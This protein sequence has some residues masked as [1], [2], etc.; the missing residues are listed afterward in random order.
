MTFKKFN[1]L[2]NDDYMAYTFYIRNEGESTVDFQW[3]LGL[4]SESKNVS[5]ACWVMIFEDGK[6][7]FYAEPNAETGK[8]E[9]LPAFDDNT[10]GYIEV[11]PALKY[12]KRSAEQL[13]LMVQGRNYDYYRVIPYSFESKD[14]VARGEMLSVDPMET[15]KYTIVIWLEGDD[16]DCTDD[17]IGGHVG[18]EMRFQLVMEEAESGENQQTILPNT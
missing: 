12:L 17:L 5:S 4:N 2:Y 11:P 6:M 14:V 9:A 13:E 3:E 1:A 15:H 8:A 18:M 7:K 10:R 16:P